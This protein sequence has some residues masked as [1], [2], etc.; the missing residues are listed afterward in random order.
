MTS[1]KENTHRRLPAGA[2]VVMVGGVAS[3]KTTVARQIA[4]GNPSA[5][6]ET[7]GIRQQL[8][9][10]ANTQGDP[11]HIHAAAQAMAE[12]RL[13]QGMSV[14]YDALSLKEADRRPLV[15]LARRYGAPV[16]AVLVAADPDESRRRNAERDRTVPEK[17]FERNVARARQVNAAKLLAEGF[18]QVHVIREGEQQDVRI[19]L[20]ADGWDRSS[21]E[22]PFDIVGD[23]HGC[24]HTAKQ[25]AHKLGY[26]PDTG[27]HPE[28]RTLVSVGDIGDRGPHSWDALKWARRLVNSG[29]LHMVAGNHE[30]KAARYLAKLAGV[31]EQALSG[32]QS[33]LEA[34]EQLIADMAA[35]S[36]GGNAHGLDVTL[37][38]AYRAEIGDGSQPDE[39]GVARIREM[40]AWLS[41]LPHHMVLDG[42]RLVV[43]HGGV[44]PDLIGR[45]DQE[46]D[47]WFLYGAPTGETDENGLPVR[48]DW[49]EVWE[50]E[51]DGAFAVGGHT[52]VKEP[53]VREHSAMLDTACVHGEDA[54]DAFSGE[55][56]V[57]YLTAMS[58]PERAFVSVE[59]HEADR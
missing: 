43:V 10:D 55:P 25:L 39:A 46:A 28:G 18:D 1:T 20:G 17:A 30:V 41:R 9:G 49:Q 2:L 57:G 6:V 15:E 32:G 59:R 12:A 14:I 51:T 13:A 56:F 31:C 26:D 40:A 23:I 5:T 29:R 52:L 36:A 27:E 7:D 58:W 24:L 21:V 22:G 54:E 4:D 38:Q 44:R 47:S 11:R 42:G 37:R 34:A 16:I 35:R 45:V 3:G 19:R 50:A 53:R 33:P 48:A 8:F